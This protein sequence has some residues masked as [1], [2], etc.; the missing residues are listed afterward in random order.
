E[1]VRM[2]PEERGVLFKSLVEAAKK[3][4][5][6]PVAREKVGIYRTPQRGVWRVNTSRILGVDGTNVEDLTRAEIE[7]RK[8]VHVLMQFFRAHL[9]G[10]AGATLLDTATQI[11]VRETRHIQGRY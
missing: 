9:P 4:G 5:E 7:G 11:G 10:F 2:H 6:F 1:Y 8:Q 3:R